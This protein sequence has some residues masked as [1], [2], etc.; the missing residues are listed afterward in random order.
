MKPGALRKLLNSTPL[1]EVVTDQRL[2][3]QRQKPDGKFSDGKHIDL[4]RY[5]AWLVQYRQSLV[6]TGDTSWAAVK[7]RARQRAADIAKEGRDIGARSRKSSTR[8]VASERCR[9]S[10]ISARSISRSRSS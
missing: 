8:C 9:T 5:A 6:G 4:L 2:Y 10:S 1:G 3:K 7:E